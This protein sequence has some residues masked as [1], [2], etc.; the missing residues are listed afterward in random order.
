VGSVR[1]GL[2]EDH[3]VVGV[4]LGE[5]IRHQPGWELVS[6][7]KSVADLDLD[8]RLDVVLL[9]L[10]LDDGSSPGDNVRLLHTAGIPVLAYTAG[11][12]AALL[13]AAAKA[14]IL[15]IVRKSDHVE[16]LLEAITR[17]AEGVAVATTD[18]AA[19]IDGDAEIADAR[20]SPRERQVLGLYASGETAA[21]V[22]EL[23]GLSKDTISD[24]VGRIRNKYALAGRPATTKV[25][26]HVRAWEDGLLP[27]R[28]GAA[29]E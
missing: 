18:W 5:V 26:L 22:A 6:V 15:G 11:E 10:R 27:R 17:A 29:E 13:R 12:D 2:V 4:G 28:R 21:G 3:E 23:M 8:S 7:V 25:A 20:L 9:D 1:I 24:Y 14:G 16:V 19:A